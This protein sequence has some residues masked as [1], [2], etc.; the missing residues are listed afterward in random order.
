MSATKPTSKAS[1]EGSGG[2]RPADSSRRRDTAAWLARR[3][4]DGVLLSYSTDMGALLLLAAVIGVIVYGLRRNQRDFVVSVPLN[5][6]AETWKFNVRDMRADLVRTASSRRIRSCELRRTKI[7]HW[8]MA[9]DTSDEQPDNRLWSAC[10]EHAQTT[11]E[12]TYRSY[13][14]RS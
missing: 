3:L 8:E 11:L 7:G 5:D 13:Q 10:E 9:D 4:D 2:P 1:K 12:S 14:G 6:R